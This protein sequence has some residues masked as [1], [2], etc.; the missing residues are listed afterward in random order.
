M[1]TRTLSI[2]VVAAF[3]PPAP[4]ATA[5]VP[6]EVQ[7]PGTQPN[8]IVPLDSV[9]SC[10][11]CHA[12]YDSLVEPWHNW[13]GSMMAHASRDPVFYAALAVA[14]E[15][16][17]GAGDL[18]IRC[19]V[20]SGWT[21]GRSTPTNGSAL[22]SS[23][24][25]DGVTCATCHKLTNPDD[26][27]H[28]GTHF[29]PFIA[30]D[31]GSPPEGYYGSAMYVLF[32]GFELLGPYLNPPALHSVKQSKY[33]RQSELC[34]TCHDVSNPIVGDLAHNHGAPT[35]LPPGSFS[36]TPGSAVNLMAAFNNPPQSY[37]VVER[38]FSEHQSSDFAGL[39]ISAYHSLPGD[40]QRGAVKRAYEA[41]IA[42]T[43]TGDYEDGTV[44]TFSCQTCHMPPVTGFGDGLGV[45]PLRR[46]LPKHS[47]NGGNYWAPKAI[48]YLDAQGALRLGGGLTPTQIAAMDDGVARARDNLEQAAALD[49]DGDTLRVT[50]LTG[51]KLITGYPEGRRMWL[52]LTWTDAAGH[53]VRVDGEYG[54]VNVQI[55]GNTVAV[56][57]LLDPHDPRTRFY[58][59]HMGMTQEWAQQLIGFGRP[60]SLPLAFD[61]ITGQVTETLGSLA[62]KPPGATTETFQFA[63]NNV[64]LEDRRIPPYGYRYDDALTRNALPVPADAYGNPGPGQTYQHFDVIRLNPPAGAVAADIELLYQP[65]SWEYVQFLLLANSGN[66]PFLGGTGQDLYDAWRATDMAEPHVMAEAEWTSPNH[67]WVDL[68]A[69]LAGSQGVPKLFGTGA[70]TAGSPTSLNLTSAAPSASTLLVVGFAAGN[71]PFY[72]GLLVPNPAVTFPSLTTDGT[73]TMVLAGTWPAGVPSGLHI[74]FQ[75]LIPDAAA[76]AGVAMSNAVRATTP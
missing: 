61:R 45:G 2:V 38:T 8:Q 17:P 68:G 50:N 3:G 19:H 23:L 5:Q 26:S 22:F 24:D 67:P 70:L 20:P 53:V 47:L 41:A 73:G 56:R 64:V 72:G 74:Y 12:G 11:Q 10:T 46:D 7:Q 34:G 55:G 43:P 32:G 59:A 75:S 37:G 63:L 25:S 62:A 39:A 42:S 14:E 18:C 4:I 76:S 66:D 15:A 6:T 58:E 28:L 16:Y 9:S 27:E 51:H 48:Q 36:G 35:P 21:G 30:N 69:G 33:H 60:A 52:R 65:I 57:T 29:P 54:D 13:S 1:R 40:M 44:R 71:I 49:V 31:G